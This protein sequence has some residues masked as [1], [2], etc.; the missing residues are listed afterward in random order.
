[1]KELIDPIA[2]NDIKIIN[3]LLDDTVD[4]NKKI[5][6]VGERL[7]SLATQTNNPHLIDIY[8]QFL[9][10]QKNI[11]LIFDTIES[12]S[13]EKDARRLMEER[14]VILYFNRLINLPS[15]KTQPKMFSL[16]V[17]N[18]DILKKEL[19]ETHG[20]NIEMVEKAISVSTIVEKIFH[21]S[22]GVALFGKKENAISAMLSRRNKTKKQ[23]KL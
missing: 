18:K 5:T 15:E 23:I 9:I 22:W 12:P 1:M 11:D 6:L 8:V 17:K 2:A 14:T 7:P 20:N 10:D 13:I 16:C 19:F 3:Q 21:K 4:I